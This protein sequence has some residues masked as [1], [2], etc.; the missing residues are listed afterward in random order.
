[1]CLQQRENSFHLNAQVFANNNEISLR[2]VR[3]L[4]F[5]TLQGSVCIY[6]R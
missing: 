3:I 6:I 1:M 4:T 2:F 5:V